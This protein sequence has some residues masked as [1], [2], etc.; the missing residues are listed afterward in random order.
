V[1]I[2]NEPPEESAAVLLDGVART[3]GIGMRNVRQRLEQMYGEKSTMHTSTNARGNF[4]VAFTIPIV[5]DQEMNGYK[6]FLT[7]DEV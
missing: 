2:E 4:E 3:S 5:R 7:A 1:L 6:L